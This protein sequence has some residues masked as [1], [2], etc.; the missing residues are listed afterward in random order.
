MSLANKGGGGAMPMEKRN[1][2][3]ESG[4]I[5]AAAGL[6][7]IMFT[8]LFFTALALALL[9]AFSSV[10]VAQHYYAGN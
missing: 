2:T 10:A 7:W 4:P 6:R 3:I 1:E 5:V 8:G 9:A